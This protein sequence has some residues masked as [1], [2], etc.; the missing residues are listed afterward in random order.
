MTGQRAPRDGAGG[1]A[2]GIAGGMAEGMDRCQAEARSAAHSTVAAANE[3]GP[4]G[5]RARLVRDDAG[6]RGEDETVDLV[7]LFLILLRHRRLLACMAGLSI[8]AGAAFA[9][10]QTPVYQAA[11]RL[12][13][14]VPSA[15]VFEDIE[16]V[17]AGTDMRALR[18]AREKILSRSLAERVVAALDLGEN[19]GFLSPTK[20]GAFIDLGRRLV[21]LAGAP[22]WKA[23][24]RAERD[25][26]AVEQLRRNLSAE[27]VADTNLI[28]IGYRSFDPDLARDVANQV[29]RSFIDQRVEQIGET[30]AL[31]RRFIEGQVGQVKERLEVSERELVDYAK[32]AG[33]TI[34]DSSASLVLEA[35]RDVNAALAVAVRE[36][37]DR[38]RWVRQIEAGNGASL[39][40][41]MDSEGLRAMR[42]RIAELKGLYQLKLA[43]FKPDYP[44]MRQLAAQIGSLR[45]EVAAG[46]SA[47]TTSMRLEYED[48]EAKEA[49]LRAKLAELEEAHS[50]FKD[51]SIRYT[52]L[53]RDVESN[54]SQYDSLA[55]KLNEI[56]VSSKLPSRDARIVDLATSPQSPIS[57]SLPAT[58]AIF[59]AL[60]TAASAGTIFTREVL[61]DAFSRQ[62]RFERELRLCVLA[63]VPAIPRGTID[64]ANRDPR[65]GLSEAYRSLRTSLR[66]A[67]AGDHPRSLLVTSAGPA[68]GKSTTV[69]KLAENF[70]ALGASV[71]VI[72]ADL[73]K[74]DLH[75]RFGVDNAVGLGDLLGNA[76]SPGDM[77]GI[78]KKTEL[79]NVKMLTSGTPPHH[80]ADL[81][82]SAKMAR[83]VALFA[84]RFD[85]VVIDS[86]PVIGLSDAPILSRLTE[87][88]VFVVAADQVS[89]PGTSAAL[90]RLRAAGAHIPGAVLTRFA[91]KQ[92]D[93]GAAAKAHARDDRP[94]GGYGYAV[95]KPAFAERT[96][97]GGEHAEP[98]HA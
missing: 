51:R 85:V 3:E 13:I 48:A 81:L 70:A 40:R 37:L 84:E 5:D 72:D 39:P 56:G 87:A 68:E 50:D 74:P 49:E 22:T 89:R 67:V 57:P 12:E 78:I 30:S 62:A 26:L 64:T 91:A 11:A 4:R 55:A 44:E 34:D 36:R 97:A 95:W 66:F 18:T 16:A 25:R 54:R 6:R 60:F 21:G 19:A 33:L 63:T 17:S 69:Y 73:R 28:A 2:G 43:T 77:R 58:M 53:K 61:C 15:K 59:L 38:G 98:A 7:R 23:M 27:L 20:A 82:A 24:S 9:M 14:F 45:S 1:M 71:L 79:A 8:L 80:A 93:Y 47:V 96:F 31:A 10:L 29:A 90:D 65:S 86:P 83:L 76:V 32:S 88:T 46:V 94:V 92:V 75:R 35:I 52:I 42:D 41:V